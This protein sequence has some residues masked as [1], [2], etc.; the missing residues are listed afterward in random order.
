M[1]PYSPLKYG[2]FS[3]QVATG[4]SKNVGVENG[5]ADSKGGKCRSGKYS[6]DNVWKVVKTENSTIL[7]VSARTK[8]FQVVFER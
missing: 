1:P 6:S 5:G 4:R 8:R 2:T 3:Q 7:G